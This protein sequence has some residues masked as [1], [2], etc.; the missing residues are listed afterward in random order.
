MSIQQKRRRRR[1]R[2][3]GKENR[4]ETTLNQLPRQS[5]INPIAPTELLSVDEIESIHRYSLELLRD[6]GINFLLPEARQYLKQAGAIIEPGSERVRFDPDMVED[7]IG[8]APAKITVHARNPENNIIIGGNHLVF[9]SVSSAPNCSDIIGGRRSGNIEDFRKFIKLAQYFN[10]IGCIGGY[11]VEPQDWHPSI[12]HLEATRDFVFLSDK[13]LRGYATEKSRLLDALEMVRIG[14]GIDAAQFARETSVMTVV[15][16]NSPLAVDTVM[17]EGIIEMAKRNQLTIITPFTLAGAM[18]PITLAGAIVQQNA[19]ALAG[20]VLSQLVRP[21]A[22]VMYGAFTSNVDMKSGS[23]AFGTPEYMKSAII[24]GQLA[25]R[26]GL[27]YRSSNTCAANAVDAQAAYESVFSLW[28]AISGGCNL[29]KHGAGW[30]EGGL[31]ASFEKFVL[32]VDMLQMVAEYLKPVQINDREVALQTIDEVGPGGHF[33]GTQH[34]QERYKTAFYAPL[35]SDWRNF[36]SWQEAGAP[37]AA[38]KA[39]SVYQQALR[40]YQAPPIDEAIREEINE[41]V[42]K[43]TAEGGVKTDF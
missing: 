33:F 39:H 11:P 18:A 36:E 14:R 10:I 35:I 22:P 37:E 43:R 16:I 40:E 28:G 29:L 9:D 27:P 4:R 2:Q 34:T 25:R 42:A 13:P 38:Q 23:P 32:D 1:P 41:F 12:R 21:G 8:L 3:N 7:L 6:I 17:A 19:E 30:L 26:Y 5:L 24:G 20:Y 31:C 15:N